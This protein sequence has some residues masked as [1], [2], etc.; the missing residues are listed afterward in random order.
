MHVKTYDKLE[1]TVIRCITLVDLNFISISLRPLLFLLDT[2]WL[3]Q[4]PFFSTTLFFSYLISLRGM[5]TLKVL[6]APAK[7]HITMYYFL[8]IAELK[9]APPIPQ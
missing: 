7:P 2:K 4:V 5:V 1:L 9:V 8:F 6:V 3:Y